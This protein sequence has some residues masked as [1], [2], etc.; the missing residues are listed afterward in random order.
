MRNCYNGR[1]G[2]YNNQKTL[3]NILQHLIEEN[4]LNVVL[5]RTIIGDKVNHSYDKFINF[6]KNCENSDIM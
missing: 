5:T 1:Q 2:I 3:G 6:L 4:I